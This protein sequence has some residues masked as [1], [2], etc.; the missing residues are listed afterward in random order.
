MDPGWQAA[1][2]N[3]QLHDVLTA[4]LHVAACGLHL[5]GCVGARLAQGVEVMEAIADLDWSLI[6]WWK[7]GRPSITYYAEH[8]A[9]QRVVVHRLVDEDAWRT[10]SL[11]QFLLCGTDEVAAV[12]RKYPRV[13]NLGGPSDPFVPTPLRA[14]SDD[15]MGCDR[16]GSQRSRSPRDG[17]QRSS[18]GSGNSDDIF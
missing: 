12:R 15:P 3:E 4:M 6:V 14:E 11:I 1:K 16:D 8:A 17:N 7:T 13:P 9:T 10:T 18:E 5:Q 2:A